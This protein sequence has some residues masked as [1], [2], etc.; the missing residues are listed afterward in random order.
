M[1]ES[2]KSILI[3]RVL[4]EKGPL[5]FK[6]IVRETGL[7]EP[8]VAKWLKRLEE[9]GEVG[10]TLLP[11]KDGIHYILIDRKFKETRAIIGKLIEEAFYAAKGYMNAYNIPGFR[12]LMFSFG[13]AL[14]M[15]IIG[16]AND[17]R[18]RKYATD[19]ILDTLE[20]LLLPVDNTTFEKM[21]IASFNR[22]YNEVSKLSDEEL[23]E[24]LR[25]LNEK[26][27]KAEEE[28]MKATEE[29]VKK[30]QKDETKQP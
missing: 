7:S 29:Q 18:M 17:D 16:L 24:Y 23:D 4:A 11:N 9:K 19:V 12:A 2:D 5:R 14:F 21:I 8:T 6:E 25:K 3:K 10:K 1:Q 22:L 13:E 20:R 30:T 27:L 15:T 28:W 26:I